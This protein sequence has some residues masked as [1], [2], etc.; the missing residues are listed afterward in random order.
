MS[1]D[2]AGAV[3]KNDPAT[4]ADMLPRMAAAQPDA[5]AIYFPTKRRDAQGQLEYVE[6]SYRELDERSDHIAAGLHAVGI[7]R[8]ERAALMVKPSPELFALTRV[9]TQV[10]LI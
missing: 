8:G 4:V 10:L 5:T 7:G 3:S 9:G 6:V 2:P 1:S